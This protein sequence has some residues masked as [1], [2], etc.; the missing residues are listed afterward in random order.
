MTAIAVWLTYIFQCSQEKH[1]QMKNLYNLDQSTMQTISNF[2]KTFTNK[3]P[4]IEDWKNQEE[5]I[6]CS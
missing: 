2:N 5:H 6:R 1:E 3:L 4:E